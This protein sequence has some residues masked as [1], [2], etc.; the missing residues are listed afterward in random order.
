MIIVLIVGTKVPMTIETS[1]DNHCIVYWPIP[2]AIE[3]SLWRKS[4][5]HSISREVLVLRHP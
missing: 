4:L 3:R 2:M 5:A 1:S